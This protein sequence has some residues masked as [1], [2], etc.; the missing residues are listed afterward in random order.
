MVKIGDK[1]VVK[2]VVVGYDIVGNLG[3]LEGGHESA[4]PASVLA[5]LLLYAEITVSPYE[6]FVVSASLDFNKA[7]KIMPVLVLKLLCHS[8]N[9]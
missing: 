1:G 2:E 8:E 4:P 3:L 6:A 7:W 5:E 9:E